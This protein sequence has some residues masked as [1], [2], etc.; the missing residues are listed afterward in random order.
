MRLA[1]GLTCL[2]VAKS[3][4][5]SANKFASV[6]PCST[7]QRK[8]PPGAEHFARKEGGGFGERHDAQVIGLA[9]ARGVRRH[10]GEHHV[11]LSLIPAPEHLFEP[12]RRCRVEKI[13]LQK[14]DPGDWLHVENVERDHPPARPGA[15]RRDLAPAAGRRAEI[16]HAR[17]RLEQVKL[18]VDLGELIGGARAEAFALGAHHIGIAEL[19][20]Q[21]GAR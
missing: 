13:E 11:R 9:M 12:V 7:L 4:L 17:A 19:A 18:V 20:L 14:L 8:L 5:S 1:G 16:H 6:P 10:V 15:A 21:P 2:T 3:R